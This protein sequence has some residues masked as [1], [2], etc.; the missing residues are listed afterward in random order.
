MSI[1]AP[2]V[3]PTGATGAT[4]PASTEVGPTG[5]EGV[6]DTGPTGPGG[7]G[8]GNT[9][10]QFVVEE[11]V[12]VPFDWSLGPFGLLGAPPTGDFMVDV[13][14]FPT[15]ESQTYELT[16]LIVQGE[17]PYYANSIEINGN[18]V[19]LYSYLNDTPPTPIAGR[20][21]IQYFKIVYIDSS[22]VVVFTKL[23]SYGGFPPPP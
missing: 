11:S 13:S 20:S 10:F 19:E 18:N 16:L 21:E 7:G 8:G 17:T 1:E 12:V 22:N 2:P 14:N 23:E 9:N 15:T 6:G 3:G 5:R 4:G